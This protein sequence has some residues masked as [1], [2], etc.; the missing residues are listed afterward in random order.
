[1]VKRQCPTSARSKNEETPAP[2][3]S[4]LLSQRPHSTIVVIVT[5]RAELRRTE[6]TINTITKG[7]T[8]DDAPTLACED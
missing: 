8:N 1:M 4:S 6:N 2:L 7:L 3:P 5:R